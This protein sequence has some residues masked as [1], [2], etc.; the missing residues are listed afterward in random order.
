MSGS[1]G[2][3]HT[4][5]RGN[6]QGKA[7]PNNVPMLIQPGHVVLLDKA[8]VLVQHFLDPPHGQP[9]RRRRCYQ[10]NGTPVPPQEVISL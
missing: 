6:N 1:A 2:L 8:L 10:A 9:S 3:S 5:I 7:K 4:P